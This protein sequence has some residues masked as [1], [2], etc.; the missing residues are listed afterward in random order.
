MKLWT[1]TSLAFVAAA[2]LVGMAGSLAG[3][4]VHTDDGCAFETHCVACQR[5]V[6]SLAVIVPAVASPSAL[7]PLG[8]VSDPSSVALVPAAIRA[9]VPRGPPQ[10]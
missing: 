2:L 6:G 3:E 4:Y 8:R 7:Q 1:R 5:V 10:A 9:E